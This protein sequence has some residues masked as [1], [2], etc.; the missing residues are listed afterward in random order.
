M[1]RTDSFKRRGHT[2]QSHAD[3][4]RETIKIIQGRVPNKMIGCDI[5]CILPFSFFES[6]EHS[7]VPSVLVKER[8]RVDGELTALQ[9][10]IGPPLRLCMTL[11]CSATT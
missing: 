1:M 8:Q 3:H 2:P 11:L 7:F 4:F 10:P 6:I 5:R 9:T